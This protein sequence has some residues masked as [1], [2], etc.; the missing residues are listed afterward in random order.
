MSDTLNALVEAIEKA[1]HAAG[2]I[3]AIAANENLILAAV[4]AVEEIRASLA[5]DKAIA[6][7]VVELRGNCLHNSIVGTAIE[8]QE[9]ATKAECA[10]RLESIMEMK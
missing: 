4:N 5:R 7:Y 8:M 6:A 2:T 9:W 3:P 1:C 10:D